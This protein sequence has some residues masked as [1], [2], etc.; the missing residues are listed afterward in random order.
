MTEGTT[1]TV[2]LAESEVLVDGVESRSLHRG[3]R[4]HVSRLVVVGLRP[5]L[6]L[7]PASSC[8][9]QAH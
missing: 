8:Q 2:R 3:G 9:P 6:T 1:Y 5:A 7:L 4:Q